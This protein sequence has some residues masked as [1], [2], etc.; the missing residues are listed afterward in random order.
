MCEV[1]GIVRAPARHLERFLQRKAPEEAAI[2]CIDSDLQRSAEAV[3]T[4][5]SRQQLSAV[6][7]ESCTAGLIAAVLSGA[8]GAS[9]WLQGG[10]VTY[11]KAQK[12]ASLGVAEEILSSSGSVSREVALAMV[13]GALARSPAAVA[14]AVTGVLGPDEDEDG[15][16]VGLIVLACAR[17]GVTPTVVEKRLPKAEPDELRHAAVCG[18]LDIIDSV[19][20]P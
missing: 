3:M 6:T 4:L 2:P 12:T 8:E 16:P 14:V 11:T 19:I 10:F 1:T 7:A 15:N 9:R 17:R 20:G 13:E 5:L 18:A